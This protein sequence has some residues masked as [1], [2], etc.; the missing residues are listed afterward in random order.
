[1]ILENLIPIAT[2]CA[3]YQVNDHFFNNLEANGLVEIQTVEEVSYV[4]QDAI[5]QIEKIIRI[6]HE[7][8]INLEGIDA[9][10]NL[11]EK[12]DSLQNELIMAKNRLLLYE[13]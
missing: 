13:K 11:L 4:G 5:Y 6:H 10:L 7:L 9:V 2:L 8:E 1:M 12:I 3:H